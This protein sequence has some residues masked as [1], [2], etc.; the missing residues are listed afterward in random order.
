MIETNYATLLFKVNQLNLNFYKQ[1][2]QIRPINTILLT[3]NRL[4]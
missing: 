1:N 3:L 2:N 4:T